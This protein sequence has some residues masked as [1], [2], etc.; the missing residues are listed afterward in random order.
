MNGITDIEQE[1]SKDSEEAPYDMVF[2]DLDGT[3]LPMELDEFLGG[4]ARELGIFF[5][6][7]GLD[8][9]GLVHDIFACTKVM[10]ASDAET[11]NADA[12]WAAFEG[13]GHARAEFEALL[14]GFYLN[15]FERLG[16]DVQ[17]NPSMTGA[18]AALKEKG[19]RLAV[20][21]MPLFPL[22]A[23]EARLR[24]AGLDPADFEFATTYDSAHSVKPHRAYYAEALKRAGMDGTAGRVLMVGNN[25]L[26]DG[27]ATKLGCDIFLIEDFLLER[28][29]GVDL[30]QAKHGSSSDFLAFC[31]AL[32]A[33]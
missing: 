31:Q 20:T 25:T 4:Y 6:A 3:L 24:W 17:P 7:R 27:A 18:V 16:E 9:E 1:Q 32:P 28:E 15:E 21:T 2:F 23:V 30:N 8:A 29:G 22:I 12:F 13:M 33:R 10:G 11:L 26:E 14:E 19:Y 5:A